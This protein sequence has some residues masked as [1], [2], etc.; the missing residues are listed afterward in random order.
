MKITE[1]YQ[2]L[3]QQSVLLFVTRGVIR[4]GI[5]S[6]TKKYRLTYEALQLF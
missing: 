1:I 6:L 5:K 3:I 4:H 2:Q